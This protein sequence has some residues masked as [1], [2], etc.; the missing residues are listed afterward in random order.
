MFK[1]CLKDGGK[2]HTHTLQAN[3]EHDKRQWMTC[4]K[5]V[6]PKENITE[7]HSDDEGKENS[8]HNSTKDKERNQ[9]KETNQDKEKNEETD[10]NNDKMS[11][12]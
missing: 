9:E 2:G 1:V 3:D 4:L 11:P 5:E 7:V 10:T 8:R 6:L 12:K